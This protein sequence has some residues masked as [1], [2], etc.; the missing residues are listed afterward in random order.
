M[1]GLNGKTVLVMGKGRVDNK[2]ID[3]LVVISAPASF[4]CSIHFGRKH[5]TLQ[6]IALSAV[7]NIK[8]GVAST[9]S[10]FALN[11]DYMVVVGG[12][13]QSEEKDLTYPSSLF[14]SMV[15]GPFYGQA[16]CKFKRVNETF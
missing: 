8:D 5:N 1:R 14:Q 2:Y 15:L 3:L 16:N 12:R 10:A 4:V 7:F 11:T 9:D 6:L 13:D